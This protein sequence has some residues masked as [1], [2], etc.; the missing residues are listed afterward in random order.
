MSNG[1]RSPSL[2]P[3][4]NLGML[5][6]AAAASGKTWHFRLVASVRVTQREDGSLFAVELLGTSG[7]AAYDRLVLGQ[8][9]SL[10]ALQLGPPRQGLETLWAFET[11]FSQIPPLPIAGCALDDFIPRNCWYPLQKLVR[12]RVRLQAI[13]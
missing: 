5:R 10:G 8:A 1:L 3:T 11:E 9:R 7:N 2:G 13:Y 6:A 4:L 12:S